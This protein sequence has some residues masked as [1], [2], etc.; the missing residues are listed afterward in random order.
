[1][2]AGNQQKSKR[3]KLGFSNVFH[4]KDT[5]ISVF[6]LPGLLSKTRQIS[7]FQNDGV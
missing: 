4:L 6:I 7:S 5:I 1:M 3:N 2:T